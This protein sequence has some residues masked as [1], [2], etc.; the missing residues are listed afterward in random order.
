MSRRGGSAARSAGR[1]ADRE[2]PGGGRQ[3]SGRPRGGG[4]PAA[5]VTAAAVPAAAAREHTESLL[6]VYWRRFKQHRLGRIGASVLIVLYALALFADPLAPA[7]MR[8]T[9]KTKSYQPPTGIRF[10]YL[11][12][13][14]LVVRPFVY[15]MHIVNQALRTYGRVP[16]RTLRVISQERAAGRAELRSVALQEDPAARSRASLQALQRHYRLADTDPRLGELRA[17]IDEVERDPRRDLH[18]R[19]RLHRAGAAPETLELI[20]AKGNKNYLGLFARGVPYRFLGLFTARIH[21]LASPTGG[22]FPLG[23]D[24]TGRDLLSR[25]LHGARV[26]LTVGL[27]GAAITLVL[28]LLIGG[29]AGYFGGIAD[30]LLMR[31]TEV[32]LSF[33]SFYLLLV[34]RGTFP[35]TLNSVQVYF[36]IIVIVSFVIWGSLARI[37]R[38]MTLSL[39][40]EDYVLSARSLGLGPF[41]IIRRH[42]LPNTFSFVI[43][44]VTLTIPGFILGESALSF[45]GLGITEPQSS[46]GL[47]LSAS[48]SYRVVQDFPW[49]LIPGICIFLAIMAWNFV[50]DGVRDAVDPRSRH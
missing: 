18:R 17:L 31:F 50:G 21:L 48:R 19:V 26:S 40:S 12:G 35:P 7:T 47:M 45:L 33:P 13:G 23:T 42:V 20:V 30:N 39:R 3:D 28:G 36:L 1:G 29:A 44:Q 43:V 34:L 27:V 49:V 38:G 22:F 14:R 32:L 8:W 16:R 2:A 11:D 46:W 41:K 15:E 25:L 4:E 24:H 6:E 5:G 10:S 9:D 37:V